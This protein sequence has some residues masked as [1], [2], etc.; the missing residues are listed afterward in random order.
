[1]ANIIGTALND[2]LVGDPDPLNPNDVLNSSWLAGE[3]T[4]IGGNG[5]DTYNVNSADDDVIEG[6]GASS[7]TDT[8]Q[9]QVVSY[10]LTDNVEN[11]VLRDQ[12]F[13]GVVVGPG[14]PL[15]LIGPPTAL[16]GT[17][18]VLANTITGNSL[19]NV[20]SGL[21]GAD[22]LSGGAGNDWLF[23][24]TDNDTLNGDDNDDFLYGEAGADTLNGGNGV[25]YLNGGSENDTMNGGSGI[26]T[27]VGGT[28]NDLMTGGT[29]NDIYYVDAA[30]DVV[31]EGALSW[32]NG[33]DT[34]FASVS[35]TLDANVE[36]LTL[37]GVGSISGYGNDS[38][39]II[40]GNNAGNWIDGKVGADTMSGGA[41]YDFYTVDNVLDTVTEAN[42]VVDGIDTVFSTVTYTITDVDV[43]SLF[44]TGVATINGTGNASNN[45]VSGNSMNNT[46]LGLGGSDTIY[47]NS[48]DDTIQGGSG[49]DFIHGGLGVDT[50]RAVDNVAGAN[51]GVE[52]R[53]Y[54]TTT[55]NEV[56]NVDLI[57]KA[58]FNTAD[59]LDDEI[60][61]ENSIF[62]ALSGSAGA[63]GTLI[64]FFEGAGRTGDG[65]F[66]PIG[67][68]LN[69]T[70]GQ[71]NYNF[72]FNVAN[73]AVLFA[74]VN[75]TVAGGSASLDRFDF[76][77]V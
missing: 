32:L 51:D 63:T 77:L 75:N 30:G 29:G 3:D 71:L 6:A 1:M 56:T 62:G 52:D 42:G 55:L 38:N 46:L 47:G 24:G 65:L 27:L 61:L 67:I 54:F 16:N 7:G 73:D 35:E 25:D 31:V 70:N 5:D 28:G 18:N 9:S 22:I 21:A 68:Y 4:M 59:G 45:T 53:F 64:E 2:N 26:D 15:L 17:G 14:F 10:T 49:A 66:D 36:N 33:V 37:T 34:V 40:N 12:N 60:Y 72:T 43:E 44:L 8:V 13:S 48:G 41:G 58:T 39:N 50:L 74:V 23:G 69:T 57:D 11:L 19:N 76:T 20:L